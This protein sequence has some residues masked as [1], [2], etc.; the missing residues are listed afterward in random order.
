MVNQGSGIGLSITKEFVRIHG[1][2][3]A[4]QSEPDRGTCFT[5]ELPVREIATV[6]ETNALADNEEYSDVMD[7]STTS[8]DQPGKG[9]KRKP[10]L[11]LVE[12]NEDFRFYLKDNLRFRYQVIEAQ[13]GKDGWLQAVNHI[14]DLIVSD[15]MMPEMNG[16]D[17]CR[18]LR[19]D[20]R[21]SHIPL[22]LLTARS[23]E[24]QVKQ[25]F[26]SGADDYVVKPFSFEIL[27]ARIKNMLDRRVVF[28]KSFNKKVDIKASEIKVSSLDE[29]LIANAVK[30]VEEKIADP[31]FSVEDLSHELGMSRVHLYKKLTS[32]TGKSPIEFIRTIRLQHAAQ[33]LEKSQ[34][35]VASYFVDRCN[36]LAE[37]ITR[38]RT[39][40][41]HPRTKP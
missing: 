39:T 18:K 1:G 10:V 6:Q 13:N 41:H 22:I 35:T 5:I 20:A 15:V 9:G 31:D 37:F 33:L 16:I 23:A 34:L 38:Q 17:F 30:Y 32:L 26:E 7:V 25:G 3:I 27:Q 12:D 40:I 24:D 28:Q 4:V 29:K 36:E 19:M 21:T 11:L 8:T 14:P 2:N